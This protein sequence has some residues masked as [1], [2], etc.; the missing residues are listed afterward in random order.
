MV[1]S[2]P[3]YLSCEDAPAK[4]DTVVLFIGSDLAARKNK[5][6][7]LITEGYADYLIIPGYGT[8][9]KASSNEGLVPVQKKFSA[10]RASPVRQATPKHYENTHR[11]ILFAKRMMKQCGF[12]SAIFVSHSYHMR[13]IKLITERV[14]NG[15]N[16]RISFVPAWHGHSNKFLWWTH[17]ND[18]KMISAEYLKIVWFLV[19]YTFT[20]LPADN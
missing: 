12:S 18:L 9:F 15:S 7:Q 6:H 19:Y 2:A 17:K 10:L 5:A 11:E 14:F 4:A 13:R 8:I 3:F 1:V 16:C 20:S